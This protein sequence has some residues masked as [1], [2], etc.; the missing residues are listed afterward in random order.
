M[1]KESGLDLGRGQPVAG[2]INNVVDPTADPV[3]AL[4][5]TPSSVTSKLW[6]VSK[7]GDRSR[8]TTHIV[9][10]VDIQICVHVSL[11]CAPHSASHAWPGLFNGQDSL[12]IVAVDFFAGDWIN[13][14]RLN[15]K[16]W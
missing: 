7:E 14:R 8:E 5:I 1:L 3:V 16:E 6:S 4:M 15:A 12:H 2:N 9:A 10:F 11:M 13:D